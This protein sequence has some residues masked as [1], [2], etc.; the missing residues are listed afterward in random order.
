MSA[1]AEPPANPLRR[2]AAAPTPCHRPAIK[3]ESR[4]PLRFYS[5]HVVGLERKRVREK[6]GSPLPR[7]SPSSVAILRRQ[8]ATA[9][10]HTPGRKLTA[11]FN[12]PSWRYRRRRLNQATRVRTGRLVASP[13]P[14]SS[15]HSNL[16]GVVLRCSSSRCTALRRRRLPL[17]RGPASAVTG[18]ASTSAGLH[19][20]GRASAS[21]GVHRSRA[22]TKRGLPRCRPCLREHRPPLPWPRLC[23]SRPPPPQL[24]LRERRRPQPLATPPST[25]SGRIRRLYAGRSRRHRVLA[26]DDAPPHRHHLPPAAILHCR[27]R[28]AASPRRIR[29][30]GRRIR[31]ALAVAG[32]RSPPPSRAAPSSRA[33]EELCRFSWP[34]RRFPGWPRGFPA[35]A[36]W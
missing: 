7:T 13:S 2:A 18:R 17:V 3:E 6:Y 19:R 21:A 28:I 8:A 34:R 12:A 31:R 22:S 14:P 27:L 5:I 15:N 16:T 35:A 26:E 1:S 4:P 9:R 32:R 10:G 23:E 30:Q 36:R 25:L 29:F 24:H 11:G 33:E 20:R